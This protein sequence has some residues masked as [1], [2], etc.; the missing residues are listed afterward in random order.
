MNYA[1]A[2]V[3]FARE[4]KRE[5][6]GGGLKSVPVLVSLILQHGQVKYRFGDTF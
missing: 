3:L 2:E 4:L 5:V 1:P 6:G